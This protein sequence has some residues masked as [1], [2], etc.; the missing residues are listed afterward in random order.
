MR[1]KTL[2]DIAWFL[3][4]TRQNTLTSGSCV[5]IMHKVL[6]IHFYSFFQMVNV[7]PVTSKSH[8]FNQDQNYEHIE[9]S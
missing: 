3:G 7:D 5:P 8:A 6:G 4:K 9:T 1:G 2:R